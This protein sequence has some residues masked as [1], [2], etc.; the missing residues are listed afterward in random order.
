MNRWNK[1]QQWICWIALT[2]VVASVY[3]AFSTNGHLPLSTKGLAEPFEA[4]RPI[5][6]IQSIVLC[7][8]VLVPPLWF[9][10]EYFFLYRVIPSNEARH[11]S[12]SR[13]R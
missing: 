11:H 12:A 5:K 9:W 3:L 4:K 13:E 2:G 8:W 1:W 7:V 10:F 6:V